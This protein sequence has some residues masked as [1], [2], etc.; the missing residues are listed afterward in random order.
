MY[1]D[2]QFKV[3]DGAST[4]SDLD[5]YS[6]VGLCELLETADEMSRCCFHSNKT[7]TN[8]TKAIYFLPIRCVLCIFII[9][10]CIFTIH[11]Y[12]FMYIW[13]LHTQ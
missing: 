3:G 5:N 4:R 11:T 7:K 2:I 12:I 6:R 10:T 1:G 8:T 13:N 9:C